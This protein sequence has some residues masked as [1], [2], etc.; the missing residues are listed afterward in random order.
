MMQLSGKNLGKTQVEILRTI[1]RA[2]EP[3]PAEHLYRH[4]EISRNATYQHLTALERDGLIQ[5]STLTQTKGRPGQTFQLTDKGL[6]LF[7]RHYTLFTKML[8][9]IIKSH[10]GKDQLQDYLE[11]LGVSLAKDFKGRLVGLKDNDLTIEV[12][13]IMQELGYEAEAIQQGNEEALQVRAYNCVFHDLAKEH[14]EVCALDIAL[15]SALLEKPIEHAECIVRGGAC[16][17][18]CIKK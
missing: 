3:L 2:G 6:E 14:E 15:I 18:F 17:R 5:K 8:M 16:C 13:K 10:I 12:S 9:Q 1:L 4:L 11:E 7:P